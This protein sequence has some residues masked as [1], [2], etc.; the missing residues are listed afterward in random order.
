MLINSIVI[1]PNLNTFYFSEAINNGLN[2]LNQSDYMSQIL[3]FQNRPVYLQKATTTDPITLQF[4][5]YYSGLSV[6]HLCDRYQKVIAAADATLAA[7]PIWKYR[8]VVT[9]NTYQYE[10]ASYGLTTT[11]WNFTFNDLIAY[12]TPDTPTDWYYF[13]LVVDGKDYFSEPII[14]RTDKFDKW[15][16]N[17]AFPNT[18]LF[19]SSLAYNRAGNTNAVVSGWFSDHPTNSLPYIPKFYTRCE[20]SIMP[21]SPDMVAIEYLMANYDTNFIYGQQFQKKILSLGMA[22]IGVPEYMLQM[23]TEFML[24]DATSIT[25]GSV[26]KFGTPLYYQYKLY[27]PDSGTAPKA[28]WKTKR[29]DGY[30][31][32]RATMPIALGSM[33]QTAMIDPVPTPSAHIYNSVFNSIFA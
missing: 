13:K 4:H 16:N 21:D 26:N 10:G 25:M 3:Q 2:V 23:I 22:S 9:G 15:G 17:I 30:P 5:T 8:Q 27:S 18:V 24:T 32:I 14:V 1:S 12:I 31:L 6:L 29:E 20:S 11:M 28:I 33:N 19:N 7:P